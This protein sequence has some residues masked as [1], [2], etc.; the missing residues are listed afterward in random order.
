M[1]VD[2]PKPEGTGL[3]LGDLRKLVT[4]TVADVMKSVTPS[5]ESVTA[6]KPETRMDR[7]TTVQAAVQAEI[8]KIRAKETEAKEKEDLTAKLTALELATKE[9][10]PV[11]R[12]RVHKIMGWGE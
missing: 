9:K 11:E 2:A 10:A 4:D 6:P 1:T 8:E 7:S 5:G 12:S 3:S